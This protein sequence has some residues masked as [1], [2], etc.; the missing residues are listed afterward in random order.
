M[1]IAKRMRSEI[2]VTPRK[3][4]YYNI[5]RNRFFAI[6]FFGSVFLKYYKSDINLITF[7]NIRDYLAIGIALARGI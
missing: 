1:N 4:L 5:L 6:Y 2:N 3:Q 7:G